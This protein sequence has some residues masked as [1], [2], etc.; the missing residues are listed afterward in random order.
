MKFGLA[1]SLS[2]PG[3]NATG[4]NNVATELEAKRLGLLHDLAPGADLIAVLVNPGRN[5]SADAQ[6]KGVQE[7][8]LVL[9]RRILVVSAR[10]ASDIELAFF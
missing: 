7:A 3:R 6:V 2:R 1:D 10:N 9:G 5:A 8:A 4:I